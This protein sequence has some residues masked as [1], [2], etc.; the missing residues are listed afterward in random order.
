MLFISFISYVPNI[1][2][3][4]ITTKHL[5]LDQFVV[6]SKI[7][8]KNYHFVHII[9]KQFLTCQNVLCQNRSY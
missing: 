4:F 2:R 3:M 6:I 1:L 8:W 7:G 5:F 9:C